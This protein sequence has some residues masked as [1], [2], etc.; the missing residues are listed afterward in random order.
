MKSNELVHVHALLCEVR[1][2]LERDGA[3]PPDAFAAYED[4]PVRPTHVHRRKEAHE[5]A[6]GHLLDGIQWALRSSPS[7][8][9]GPPLP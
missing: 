3:V 5:R 9:Q 6:I 4:Q 2:E 8:E 7:R 1:A